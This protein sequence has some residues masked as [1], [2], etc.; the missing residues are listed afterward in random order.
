MAGIYPVRGGIFYVLDQT[1]TARP[2]FIR[3]DE[4]LQCHAAKNTRHVPGFVVRSVY[5]DYRGYPIC[6][7]GS[8]VTTH[9]SPLCER[10]GGWYVTG[11]HGTARLA[12][13]LLFEE[14][15]RPD[16]PESLTGGNLTSLVSKFSRR[17]SL[18]AQ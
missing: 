11:A 5:P 12:G 16:N 17:E 10:W 14:T 2:K 15:S 13:N 18:S 8:R 4:C 1:R 9:T 3:S 7:L 6:S